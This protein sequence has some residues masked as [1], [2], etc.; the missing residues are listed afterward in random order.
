M[1][2]SDVN[3]DPR[4]TGIS[5]ADFVAAGVSVKYPPRTGGN[6]QTQDKCAGCD[7]G[8][9]SGENPAGFGRAE[10]KRGTSR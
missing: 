7:N 2:T 10:E 3:N 9:D 5:V 8:G 4:Q 6:T 1:P